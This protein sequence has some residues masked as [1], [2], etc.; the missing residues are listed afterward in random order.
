MQHNPEIMNHLLL[1][2]FSSG[3]YIA[4]SKSKGFFPQGRRE[5]WILK[6]AYCWKI[7]TAQMIGNVIFDVDA[8][9][10]HAKQGR[11]C[12]LYGK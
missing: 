12:V 10:C 8:I 6:I 2:F 5:G 3:I 11:K 7:I 1:L 9:I 4:T